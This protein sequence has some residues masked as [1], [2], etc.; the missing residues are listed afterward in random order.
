MDRNPLKGGED[1]K[2]REILYEAL[3]KLKS[4]GSAFGK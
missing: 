2:K 3:R 1:F 4:L